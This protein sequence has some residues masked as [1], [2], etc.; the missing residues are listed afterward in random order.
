MR[1][2]ILAVV[3][4]LG[5]T[6]SSAGQDPRGAIQGRVVDSS[7]GALPG[8]TVMVTNTA[9]GT[10]NTAV[11]DAEGRYSIP[12]ITPGTY[13]VV[14]E[15]TGFKRAER[16]TV[17]VRIADRLELDFSLEV[18]G[19]E[20]TVTVDGGTPL[21]ETRSASQGQ[22]IDEKRIPLMPLSDGN[23]F[24]L[25]RLAAGTVYTGDLKFSRPFDNAGTSAST[26]TARPAA[27]SS[28]STARPTWPTAGAWRSCRRPAPCRS[29]RSRP[30]RSTR[31]RATPPARP[32]T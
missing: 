6:S 23:P 8:T 2:A 12:F 20:E 30:R 9:N 3:C 32:S 27:T 31:S 14:V 7:G 22:V 13:D 15:L 4:V 29:S 5:F 17:E 10:A 24:M 21:L 26:P 18:G 25:A 16:K 11:T 28:R 19:L 1:A